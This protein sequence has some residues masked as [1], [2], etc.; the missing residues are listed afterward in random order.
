MSILTGTTIDDMDVKQLAYIHKSNGVLFL[1]IHIN[2]AS[3]KQP[4]DLYHSKAILT[5]TL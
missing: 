3:D 1:T 5:L 4:T 2:L